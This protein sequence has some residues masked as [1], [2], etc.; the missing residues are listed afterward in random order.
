ME[1]NF[2]M[3]T[4]TGFCIL[5]VTFL[6]G[7]ALWEFENT[8]PLFLGVGFSWL[9]GHLLFPPDT[10]TPPL[11]VMDEAADEIERLRKA[12]EEVSGYV[13]RAE[14]FYMTE[15]TKAVVEQVFG[16]VKPSKWKCPMGYASCKESCGNYGC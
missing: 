4:I 5:F 13:A 10:T 14:W 9:V 11:D 6:I 3:K 12:L 16:E 2:I 1:Q 15:E 7:Y 8:W